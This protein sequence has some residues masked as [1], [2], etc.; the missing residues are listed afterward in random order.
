MTI[1]FGSDE[2]TELTT[3][4]VESLRRRGHSL[5]LIG[6]AA[7]MKVSWPGVGRLVGYAVVRGSADMGIVCCW[8]G[9]GVSIAANKVAGVRAALCADAQTA[10]GARKWNDANVLALSNRA[11]S[12]PIGIEILDAWFD[13]AASTDPADQNAIGEIENVTVLEHIGSTP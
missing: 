12:V 10:S 6:A 9:T 7:G 11:T 8:T 2:Q 5:I 1:A 13:A 3:A 4:L